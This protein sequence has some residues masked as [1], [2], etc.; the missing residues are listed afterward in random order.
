MNTTEAQASM[1]FVLDDEPAVRDSLRDLLESEHYQVRTFDSPK[2]FLQSATAM[3]NTCLILD[4]K[5]P[6]ING[7]D[8]L[9]AVMRKKPK[10]PTIVLTAYAEVPAVVSAMKS[11]AVN[12]LEKPCSDQLLLNA[13]RDALAQ[14]EQ[15]RDQPASVE[16]LSAKLSKLSQRE[17]EILKE[18]VAGQNVKEIA[19]KLGT[20][21]NTVRN[22]RGSILEKMAANS[23][24]DLV[25]IVLEAT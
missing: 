24:A 21:P 14:S 7:L 4:L 12:L 11:G 17:R 22:Q 6:E 13:V 25:R 18:L 16:T 20:S 1:V 23:M 3:P 19:L 8:V 10:L 9:Q 5:M 15:R 2:Q